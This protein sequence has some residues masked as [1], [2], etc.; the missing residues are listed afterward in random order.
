MPEQLAVELRE[1]DGERRRRQQRRDRRGPGRVGLER[2]DER[3]PDDRAVDDARDLL[4]VE[5]G[6][7]RGPQAAAVPAGG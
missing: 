3:E 2:R 6:G 1:R 7:D 4:R 5:V